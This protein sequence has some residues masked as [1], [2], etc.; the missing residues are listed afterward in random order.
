MAWLGGLKTNR[1]RQGFKTRT[2]GMMRLPSRQVESAK[3]HPRGPR[4]VK[5]CEKLFLK[6]FR[7][8][9]MVHYESRIVRHFNYYERI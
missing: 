4:P 6:I 2:Q 5:T 8:L 1:D 3:S 9:N 7:N